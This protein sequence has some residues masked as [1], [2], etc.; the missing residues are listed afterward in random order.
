[1]CKP[2]PQ[3]FGPF[4]GPFLKER[5]R[6]GTLQAGDLRAAADYIERLEQDRHEAEQT[7]QHLLDSVRG[8]QRPS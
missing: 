5:L 1:M 2:P 3:T 4:G 6:R 8:L 7:Y